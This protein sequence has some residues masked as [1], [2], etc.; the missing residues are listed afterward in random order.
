MTKI[1][2]S[3]F[4]KIFEKFHKEVATIKS[5][6]GYCEERKKVSL[7]IKKAYFFTNTVNPHSV[8]HGVL[9]KRLRSGIAVK[10]QEATPE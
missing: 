1:K 6:Q 8:Y 10:F 2:K 9:N 4:F 3:Y 5:C 7:T